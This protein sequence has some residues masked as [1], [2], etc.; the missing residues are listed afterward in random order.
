MENCPLLGRNLLPSF[1]TALCAGEKGGETGRRRQSHSQAQQLFCVSPLGRGGPGRCVS[2]TVSLEKEHFFL[3]TGILPWWSHCSV[4]VWEMLYKGLTKLQFCFLKG[5]NRCGFHPGNDL[6]HSQK[7]IIL[8]L[9]NLKK[10]GSECQE[11]LWKCF[12]NWKLSNNLWKATVSRLTKFTD[13]RKQT[14]EKFISKF[15]NKIA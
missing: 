15:L 14:L 10:R 11:L 9:L 3:K 12:Q 8:A 6:Q 4:F 2:V 7:P 13:T 5:S 1:P